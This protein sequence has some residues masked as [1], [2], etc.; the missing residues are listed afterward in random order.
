VLKDAGGA[1]TGRLSSRPNAQNLPKHLPEFA[2]PADLG[3]G[4]LPNLRSYIEAPAGMTFVGVDISQQ[5]LRIL[6]HFVPSIGDWYRVNPRLDLHARVQKLIRDV[7]GIELTRDIVKVVN[8]CTIY[9]GGANAISNQARIP[10]ADARRFKRLHSD[11]LPGIARW[12][13]E[14]HK[15]DRFATAGGRWYPITEGKEYRDKNYA[16]QGSAADQLKTLMIAA[17][18]IAEALG[19]WLCLTAHDELLTC[20][21]RE[22]AKEMREALTLLAESTGVGGSREMFD[23]PMFCETYQGKRWLK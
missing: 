5:E 22:R 2:V 10:Y 8:F 12:D 20:V 19:G 23:V 1:V 7:S 4:P 15:H 17:A 3:V 9:G 6:G 13:W 14:M 16:I 18:P 21:P 11:A